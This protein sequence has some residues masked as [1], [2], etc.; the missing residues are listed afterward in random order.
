MLITV[1]FGYFGASLFGHLGESFHTDLATHITRK[2]IA[3]AARRR[4]YNLFTA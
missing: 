3:V 4:Y 2:S 1:M